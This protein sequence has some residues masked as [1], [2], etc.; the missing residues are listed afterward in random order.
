MV[1][2]IYYAHKFRF[3][4]LIMKNKQLIKIT[5]ASKMN[6][7]LIHLVTETPTLPLDSEHFYHFLIFCFK[8][9]KAIKKSEALSYSGFFINYH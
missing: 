6:T 9:S 4:Q 5:S 7:T 8:K 2:E 3:F 1:E